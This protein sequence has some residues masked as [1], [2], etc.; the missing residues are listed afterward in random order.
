MIQE[1]DNVEEFA[2]FGRQTGGPYPLTYDHVILCLGVQHDMQFYDESTSKF[3]TKLPLLVMCGSVLNDR[4]RVLL[5]PMMQPNKKYPVMTHEYESLNQ[6]GLYFAGALTHGKDFKR[7]AGGLVHGLRYTARAMFHILRAKYEDTPWPSTD[8]EFTKSKADATALAEL[9]V[10]LMRRIDEA[11]APYQMLGTLGDGIIF[12]CSNWGA[13]NPSPDT[14]TAR[15]V[16]DQPVHYLN[17]VSR[18][19]SRIMW[20]FGYD[21]QRRTLSDTLATGTKHEVHIWVYE[22]VCDRAYRED[23]AAALDRMNNVG[24]GVPRKRV[25]VLTEQLHAGSQAI[26]QLLAD[27]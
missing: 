23:P 27:F 3:T 18:N 20:T 21:G 19:Q 7:S 12:D 2:E 17:E 16:E 14:V 10:K 8:F 25:M 1:G 26:R 9:S 15:Y 22:G 5:V 13:G 4:L 24:L 6:P 11:D